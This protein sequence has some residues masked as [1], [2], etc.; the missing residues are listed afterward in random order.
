MARRSS[1]WE[2][3]G[4]GFRHACRRMPERAQQNKTNQ[5]G[6][7]A[8][9]KTLLQSPHCVGTALG[10]APQLLR[11]AQGGAQP[12]EVQR[13][14]RRVVAE[15]APEHDPGAAPPRPL[16]P[17]PRPG[18]RPTPRSRRAGA[19]RGRA[20]AAPRAAST[21]APARRARSP[22][23]QTSAAAAHRSRASSAAVESAA[24]LAASAC[25]SIQARSAWTGGASPAW[26]TAPPSPAM[27]ASAQARAIGAAGAMAAHCW[28]RGNGSE[29]L[30][31]AGEPA[32][33]AS[34]LLEGG[35]AAS[36]GALGEA[37][38]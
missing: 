28:R 29:N 31:R 13:R 33:S 37:V 6:A 26:R 7:S 9:A 20:A 24:G 27:S 1:T 19:P 23:P 32:R 5:N 25:S 4:C 3:S 30:R 14:Q 21:T 34:Q 36:R 12:G 8:A 18:A 22:P 35:E 2:L 16:R 15:A 11:R 10:A 38:F 17:P